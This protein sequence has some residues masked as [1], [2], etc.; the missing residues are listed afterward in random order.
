MIL[1]MA[2]DAEEVRGKL[3]K[4][5]MSL[6]LGAFAPWVWLGPTRRTIGGFWGFCH[7]SILHGKIRR[8]TI[9]TA[10]E[11]GVKVKMVTGDQI[12]IAKEMAR[13]L[14]LGPNIVDASILAE[15]KHYEAGQLAQAIEEA[16]GFAQVSRNTNFT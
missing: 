3:R 2:A 13:Q 10:F 9:A 11:M 1:D 16:D 7:C 8:S 4:Q 12:A 5:S 15:G 6:R 14:G